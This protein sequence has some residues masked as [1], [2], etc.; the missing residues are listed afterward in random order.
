[1]KHFAVSCSCL[2]LVIFGLAACKS[3]GEGLGL[4]GDNC[5]IDI[6]PADEDYLFAEVTYNLEAP[7]SGERAFVLTLQ[8]EPLMADHD[9]YVGDSKGVKLHNDPL[10]PTGGTVTIEYT[11]PSGIFSPEQFDT[12]F[13]NITT[14]KKPGFPRDNSYYTK[15]AHSSSPHYIRVAET[16]WRLDLEIS[17][18]T[19]AL[20][21]IVEDHS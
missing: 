10:A 2:L 18:R 12:S 16:V 3:A 8:I 14:V 9:V 21:L 7:A 11:P 1:L 19:F 17:G 5:V 6:R 13:T 20:T 15:G 4:G